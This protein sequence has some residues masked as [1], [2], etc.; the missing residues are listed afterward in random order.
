VCACRAWRAFREEPVQHVA[1][2]ARHERPVDPLRSDV[3]F[4]H[5]LRDAVDLARMT[6]IGVV[7]DFCSCWY[8]RG[9][10]QL[11]REN[12]DLVTLVQIG[13]YKLGT[14]DIPNR[15]AIPRRLNSRYAR[16]APHATGDA[17]EG[18]WTRPSCASAPSGCSQRTT[19]R[20]CCS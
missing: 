3:S 10:E 17:E 20:P 4:V 1:T 19:R 7:V 11:V 6:G 13:D 18:P 12:V 16:C 9:L 5:T 14:Y 15:A 8:E 2:D